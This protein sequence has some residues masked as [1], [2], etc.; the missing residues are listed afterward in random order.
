MNFLK[1]QDLCVK[2]SQVCQVIMISFVPDGFQKC[3]LIKHKT[4][5]LDSALMIFLPQ[6]SNE[7]EDFINQILTGNETKPGF[8]VLHQLQSN[9]QW[10]GDPLKPQIYKNPKQQCFSPRDFCTVFGTEEGSFSLNFY[11]EAKQ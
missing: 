4:K 6:Y 5:R 8:D 9:N 2:S 3:L 10:N 11:R 1:F 7:G